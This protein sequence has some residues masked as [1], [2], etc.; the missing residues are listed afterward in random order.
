MASIGAPPPIGPTIG[1]RKTARSAGTDESKLRDAQSQMASATAQI[2]EQTKQIE[3]EG[4]TQLDHMKENYERDTLAETARTENQV[5]SEKLKGYEQLRDLQRTQNAEISRVKREGETELARLNNYYRDA[6]Y[7][8]QQ[9]GDEELRG[10]E[11]KN[12]Q[13]MNFENSSGNLAV[14]NLQHNKRIEIEQ[15]QADRD[16]Q[17][18]ILEK[19]AH[20]LYDKKKIETQE[21]IQQ[22]SEKLDHNYQEI[23]K[24]HQDT[25]AHLTNETSAQL[26][27]A[28]LDSSRKLAAYN[29]RQ[30]DP[31]YQM[32]D[33]Q[34]NFE[35]Q[36][37][38]YVLTARIPEHEQRHVS[39]A[40]RGN[41]VVLSGNRRSE[42]RVELAPG[43]E[44]G[45][46][47]YQSFMESFPFP[48]PVESAKLTHEFQGDR[49]IVTV[50]KKS[51]A[52]TYKPYKVKPARAQVQ[53]PDFPANLPHVGDEFS[54]KGEVIASAGSSPLIKE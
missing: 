45:T 21:A 26:Q 43:H 53:K 20:D 47:S 35:D 3:Q 9:R 54:Q 36:G 27:K 44:K 5:A 49:V 7:R 16:Q 29:E 19:Q 18:S 17:V 14:E 24:T 32:L 13:Q 23:S 15:I 28:R 51:L 48:Q 42:E 6:T 4:Q 1:P 2:Q 10:T 50:P 22:S 37:D 8:A 40:I 46:N 52:S 41:Q 38:K 31:F 30:E 12:Q 33:L 34:A 11:S 39:V 25:M